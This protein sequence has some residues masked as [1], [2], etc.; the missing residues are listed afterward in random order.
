MDQRAVNDDFARRRLTVLFTGGGYVNLPP[1]T[2]QEML[3]ENRDILKQALAESGRGKPTILCWE[4]LE[5]N[6]ATMIGWYQSAVDDR[7]PQ[8]EIVDIL[9][10]QVGDGESWKEDQ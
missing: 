7:D 3:D 1:F 6:S 5:F 4:F 10:K 8:R 2:T 9:K